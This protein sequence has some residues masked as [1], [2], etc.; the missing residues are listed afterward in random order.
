MRIAIFGAAFLLTNLLLAQ[1][2]INSVDPI[3]AQPGATVTIAGSGFNSTA[4]Q[5]LVFLGSGRATVTSATSNLLTVTVPSNAT[6]GSVIVTNLA[7][8]ESNTYTTNFILST[9][10]TNFNVSNFDG[11]SELTTDGIFLYDLCACDFDGDGDNDIAATH[12]ESPGPLDIY[13]NRSSVSAI[14]F[15]G[16]VTLGSRATI[17]VVCGDLNSDGFPDLVAS[18]GDNNGNEVFVFENTASG[19]FASSFDSDPTQSIRIPR[20]AGNNLRRPALID[21][22]DVDGDG[23]LDIV[24]GNQ[25]D[26]VIDIYLNTTSAPGG[27]L[28]FA[29]SPF[30]FSTP[31]GDEGGRLVTV[32]DL[33]GDNTPELIVGERTL[34]ILFVYRNLSTEG[35]INFGDG[36]AIQFINT[37]LRRIGVADLNGDGR[38][39][40]AVTDRRGDRMFLLRNTTSTTGAIPSFGNQVEV[41]TTTNQTWGLAFGDLDG[42]GDS[43]IILGSER[44]EGELAVLINNSTESELIF[45]ANGIATRENSRNVGVSDLNGDAKPDIFFTSGSELNSSGELSV[46][47]NR[48]C[49]A[50]VLSPTEGSFCNGI[51]FLLEATP[52]PNVSYTWEVDSGSGTFTTDASS[53]GNTLD[54]SGYSS[55][56]RVRVRM[57]SND[58]SCSE[59]SNVVSLDFQSISISTPNFTNRNTFCAGENFRLTTSAPADFYHWQGPNGFQ[60]TTTEAS[61]TVATVAEAIN[62]GEYTLQTENN[63]S[64]MSLVSRQTIQVFAIPALTIISEGETTFCEGESSRLRVQQVDG[65]DYQ[66]LQDG[67]EIAGETGLTIV[68]DLSAEFSM[69]LTDDNACTRTGVPLTI[70]EV[71]PPSSLITAANEICVD[72]PLDLS[73]TG[74]GASELDLTYTWDFQDSGGVSIGS[75]NEENPS[76][77]FTEEG[78]FSAN[79]ITGYTEVADCSNSASLNITASAPPTIGIEYPNGR[80]K[81]PSDSIQI[82]TAT[83]FENYFWIDI[84]DGTMD[85]LSRYNDQSTAFINT[86]TG[87]SFTDIRLS[88]TTSIGCTAMTEGSISNF[89]NAGVLIGSPNIEIINDQITIPAMTNGVNLV[90]TGGSDYR[91]RPN[92]IFSDSTGSNVV[93]FP[94][95]TA[96]E[97]TLS[98]IDTNGCLETDVVTLQNDNLLARSGFS[99]NGD[100]LGFECWEILNTSSI[101]GCTVYIFD[102]RGRN[103]LVED[104]PFE[105]DCVWDG[106]LNGSQAPVGVYY[107]T[108]KCDESQLSVSGSILLAR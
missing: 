108:L 42:D 11:P 72:V 7:N 4:A 54:I 71:S 89:S 31:A 22:A 39:D 91:W 16:P 29:S 56:L 70:R 67:S 94:R 64:C 36:N 106:N 68:A 96:T 75:S 73:A 47:T 10:A 104:S 40:I 20:D 107:Y 55:D 59:T 48:N 79:L 86:A 43:D 76:F 25:S 103:I 88:I 74:T 19:S 27:D 53:T 78:V 21:I 23:W 5:N 83:G 9:G 33:N 3:S 100:G 2:F 14:S 81:C 82:E 13:N 93:A 38:Q 92:E 51:T 8:G 65:F 17:N 28:S 84:T 6:A 99:P 97:V 44:S 85:T 12:N 18:E 1:P 46:L 98:G 45:S 30:Q 57:D 41:T 37:D 35:N 66:W 62:S 24:V 63:G 102:S 69:Q 101:T 49:V 105:N 34:D 26:N 50:P 90:A 80:E 58:G 32:R 87:E 15:G 95:R 61:V 60:Q 77:T 52:A